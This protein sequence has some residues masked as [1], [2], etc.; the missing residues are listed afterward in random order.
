MFAEQSTKG[1]GQ[2]GPLAVMAL[3]LSAPF[4]LRRNIV[5]RPH[6][7]N[8]ARPGREHFYGPGRKLELV[9]PLSARAN[10]CS[11]SFALI[12][13]KATPPLSS[14][15]P[16][17][18]ARHAVSNFNPPTTARG[19]SGRCSSR[20]PCYSIKSGPPRLGPI[21]L[22]MIQCAAAECLIWRCLG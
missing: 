22:G 15:P 9:T 6:P 16:P 13:P 5:C 14:C 7:R 11:H 20:R 8:G 21:L 4:S 10:L 3:M 17:T 18:G 12:R 19:L 1:G 2:A